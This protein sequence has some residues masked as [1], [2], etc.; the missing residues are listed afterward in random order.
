[1]RTQP[2]AAAF[3]LTISTALAQ[4][5]GEERRWLAENPSAMEA[6]GSMSR[7]EMG[8]FLETYQG[9][10]PEEKQKLR[11]HAGDLQKLGPAE[12]KWALENPDAVR[13]LG[14]LPDAE[15]EKFLSTYENLSAAE[16]QKLRE[17]ADQLG[18]LTA[19]ERAW[20]L[21]NPDTVRS[22]G[23]LPT[24]QRG[25]LLDAY[26]GLPPESQEMLRQQMGR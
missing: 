5:Y 15:R 3:L 11:D 24:E 6:L 1:M 12:R 19:E 10:S 20:A 25:A 13:Q 16:K 22:L 26:R 7:E 8:Q 23:N 14:A 4:E 18:K 17:N 2:I 9:L 21:D